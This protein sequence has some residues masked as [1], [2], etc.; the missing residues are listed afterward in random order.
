MIDKFK[1]FI[2][3]CWAVD[4]KMTVYLITIFICIVGVKTYNSLPKENFPDITVPTIYVNTVNGGNSPTNIE[5]TITKPIEKKLKAVSGIKKFTSTS[6]QDVSVIV[7]EFNTNVR[8]EDAKVKVK[9]AV[10]DA[11]SDLPQELTQEPMIKE[12][13]Y[14]EIPIMYINIAGNY[15]L[16]ELKKHAEDLQDRIEG[17]KEINEVKIVGA[18]DREIQVNIDMYKMQAAQLT[19][20]DIS[21]AIARE[22]LSITGGNGPLEGM[23][24]TLSIKGEFKD[25]K[26]IEN[27][28]ITS[29]AGAKLAL[30]DIA[31]VK[32][33]FKEKESYSS[34]K[35]KNVITLNVIKRSGE[36]LIDA[37]ENI[38]RTITELKK[39]H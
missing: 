26:E 23:K 11:R 5:N 30:K 6:L 9:D 19:F 3:S 15:D 27:I 36:N 20:Q 33:G 29:A 28:M 2:L 38:E 7:V 21:G 35:G 17:L 10:D 4:N 25:P 31:E 16:K 18:L 1:E 8:V 24:P 34:K 14:S 39:H 12:I 37:A 32:D 13:A 22:N